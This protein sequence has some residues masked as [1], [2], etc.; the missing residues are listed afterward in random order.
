MIFKS[1]VPQ[2]HIPEITLHDEVFQRC[3]MYGDRKALV[4]GATGRSYT[5]RQVE[6]LS[7]NIA[8]G[9]A[10]LGVRKGSVV[11]IILPNLPEYAFCFLGTIAAGGVATT[12]NPAYTAAEISKQLIN[13]E[14]IV[15][16]TVKGLEKT[17]DAAVR[18]APN[19]VKHKIILGDDV[20]GYIPLRKLMMDDGSA[21][22]KDMKFDLKEDLVAIPYSSGTTGL[23]KGVMLSHYNI[24]AN[25]YQICQEEFNDP[26]MHRFHPTLYE[27]TLCI[28]PMFHAYGLAIIL[29]LGL[30]CGQMIVSLP[31]FE[32]EVFLNAIQEYK[33]SVMPLVPPLIVFMAK[34]PLV[35]KYDLSGIKRVG[36][37]AA[38]LSAEVSEE[39][40]RRVKVSRLL[41]GYGMTE[42]S[43]TISTTLPD[44]SVPGSSGVVLSATEVQIIDISTGKALGRGERGEIWVR[45]PQ[46]MK[47]YYKDPKATAAT[48]DKD[49][50]LH[51][52]DVGYFD[53]E[54]HLFVV[55]RI[56]EL[57]KYKAFQVAPAELESLLLTYKGVTDA[58]VVGIPDEEAGEVPR[59]YIVRK[60]G[61]EKITAAEIQ[62]YVK[63]NVANFKQL[64]GGVE[65]VQAIPKNP[66]GKI[67]RKDL[68]KNY[69]K[70]KM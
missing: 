66:S 60:E 64:R 67:L 21:Y 62:N 55:D 58:A 33:V 69:L 5:Y 51:T 49:G 50:W 12:I 42:A 41:Q 3:R 11:A 23:P 53:N 22:P 35:K 36:S 32:P 34:S 14:A 1:I 37:G 57:I 28:I 2:I 63:E 59:A 43:P 31:R 45:G 54:D 26:K 8:S 65:F 24:M 30:R 56:K 29:I 38:P 6:P 25:Q 68:V 48:I 4:C 10:K 16:I 52:G 61:F 70:S 27:T 13:S 46:I 39:F 7:K 15:I 47:G 17:V 9:L 18:K 40:L 44:K 19:N 20:E